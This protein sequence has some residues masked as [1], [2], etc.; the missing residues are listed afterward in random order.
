MTRKEQ[1]LEM[2]ACFWKTKA[3]EYMKPKE[4]EKYND[5]LEKEKAK[6]LLNLTD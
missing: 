4:I 5:A 1:L 6:L 3:S 2:E